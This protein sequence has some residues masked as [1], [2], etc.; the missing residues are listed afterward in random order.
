MLSLATVSLAR[1]GFSSDSLGVALLFF[2]NRLYAAG[3]VT[4]LGAFRL[5]IGTPGLFFG[6]EHHVVFL[7]RDGLNLSTALGAGTCDVH[8]CDWH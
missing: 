4:F 1:E 8:F 2:L 7:D 6:E 3:H 5:A